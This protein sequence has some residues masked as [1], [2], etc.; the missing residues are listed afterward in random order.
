[1]LVWCKGHPTYSALLDDKPK[2]KKEMMKKY[3]EFVAEYCTCERPEDDIVR[4][5]KIIIG[6]RVKEVSINF[7]KHSRFQRVSFYSIRY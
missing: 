5:D 3:A 7:Q 6:D 2:E 4:E 1:M